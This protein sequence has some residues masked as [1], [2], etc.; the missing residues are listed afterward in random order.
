MVRAFLLYY[1]YKYVTRYNNSVNLLI[2][3]QLYRYK[4][5]Y[6]MTIK[7]FNKIRSRISMANMR[8][9]PLKEKD[10]KVAAVYAYMRELEKLQLMKQN[11]LNN[12]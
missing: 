7:E 10:D 2:E 6:I 8:N 3:N 9:R 11:I 5:K 4:E 1:L 12:F